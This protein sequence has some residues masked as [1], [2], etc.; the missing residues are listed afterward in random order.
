MGINLFPILAH[1]KKILTMQIKLLNKGF[2]TTAMEVQNIITELISKYSS[3]ENIPDGSTGP[4]ANYEKMINAG[5]LLFLKSLHH[6]PSIKIHFR[7]R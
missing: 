3:Y 1:I 7:F 4:L 6:F 2:I 5:M